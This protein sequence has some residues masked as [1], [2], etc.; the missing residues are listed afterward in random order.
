MIESVIILLYS[1]CWHGAGMSFVAGL[2]IARSL[3][4]QSQAQLKG[5]AV[6][7]PFL[8]ESLGAIAAVYGWTT[9]PS[10]FKILQSSVFDVLSVVR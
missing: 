2:E 3:E 10:N 9:P 5:S 4:Q 7:I 8:L 6:I 1:S